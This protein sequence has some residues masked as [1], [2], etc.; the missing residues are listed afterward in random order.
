MSK[1]QLFSSSPVSKYRYVYRHFLASSFSVIPDVPLK[2]LPCLFSTEK[3]KPNT[4]AVTE[5]KGKSI[6]LSCAL[7]FCPSRALTTE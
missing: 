1:E 7:R 5:E 6:F 2:S 4:K 3:S